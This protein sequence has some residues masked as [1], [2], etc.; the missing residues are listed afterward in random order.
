MQWN[1][2]GPLERA[3]LTAL[4]AAESFGLRSLTAEGVWRTLPG[5]ATHF[6]NV[7]GALADGAPLRRWLVAADGRFGLADASAGPTPRSFEPLRGLCKLP[8]L[9][10]VAVG[11]AVGFGRAGDGTTHLV[12]IAEGGRAPLAGWA[13]RQWL[14]GKPEWALGLTVLDADDLARPVGDALDALSM[15]T[16]RPLMNPD[17]FATLRD[18]NPWVAQALP[19]D[20]AAGWAGRQFAA[21]GPRFDGKLAA[22]RRGF[23]SAGADGLLAT[24]GRIGGRRNRFEALLQGRVAPPKNALPSADRH[25]FEARIAEL[26]AR[27]VEVPTPDAPVGPSAVEVPAAPE[28][29]LTGAATVEAAPAEAPAA[30]VAPIELERAEAPPVEATAPRTPSVSRR[31]R[32]AERRPLRSRRSG[33]ASLEGQRG[34]G[35]HRRD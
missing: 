31:Q 4:A 22:L 28:P 25:R 10:A 34:R 3:I 24:A 21:F 33:A 18:A 7:E 14:A 23:V 12:V 11:G 32:G 6:A 30:E 5:Y 16:L 35:G 15:A 1:D 2:L 27:L 9:E 17:G 29:A 20:P 19:N 8:W 26:Q 13:I